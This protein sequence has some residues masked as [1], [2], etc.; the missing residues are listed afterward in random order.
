M[1]QA[2]SR[3]AA[4]ATALAATSERGLGR[5]RP[6]HRGRYQPPVP[7]TPLACTRSTRPAAPGVG[8]FEVGVGAARHPASPTGRRP[9]RS[10]RRDADSAQPDGRPLTKVAEVPPDGPASS[11]L[12]HRR[13]PR[14]LPAAGAFRCQRTRING[15]TA[16]RNP[17]GPPS[18]HPA[19][20]RRLTS[21]SACT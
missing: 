6:P 1:S 18:G 15:G 5:C 9:A 21:P 2:E 13:S 12:G 14:S 11:P 4:A 10:S 19:R 17:R 16:G 8:A 3:A 20:Q 7:P